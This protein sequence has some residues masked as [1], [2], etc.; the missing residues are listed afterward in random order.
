MYDCF[1]LRTQHHMCAASYKLCRTSDRDKQAKDIYLIDEVKIIFPLPAAFI[2]LHSPAISAWH[3]Q[4]QHRKNDQHSCHC[5]LI[6][7]YLAAALAVYTAP[8]QFTPPTVLTSSSDSSAGIFFSK[9]GPSQYTPAFTTHTSRPPKS[10]A[11]C[12]ITLSI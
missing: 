4:H 3:H 11:T 2:T 1:P 5:S 8:S 7:L 9:I 12:T 10:C 6:I